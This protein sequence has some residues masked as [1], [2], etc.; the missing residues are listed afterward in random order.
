MM[1]IAFDIASFVTATFPELTETGKT[2][3]VVGFYRLPRCL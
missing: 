1:Q 3:A 2:R